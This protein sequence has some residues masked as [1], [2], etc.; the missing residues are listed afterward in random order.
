MF[1]NLS[2]HKSTGWSPEQLQAAKELGGEVRD[3]SFPNVPPNYTSYEVYH[4]AQSIVRDVIGTLKSSNDKDNA[5]MVQ[6]EFSLTVAIVGFLR[7][8]DIL[9]VV[10]TSERTVEEEVLPDGSTVKKSVFK[11]VQFREI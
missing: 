10:S 4:L 11:F 2:N 7:K 6:G 5:I 3:F 8:E 1:I 9:M